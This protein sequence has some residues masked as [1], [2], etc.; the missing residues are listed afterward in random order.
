MPP[1]RRAK[2]PPKKSLKKTAIRKKRAHHRKIDGDFD[3]IIN[4]PTRLGN[5]ATHQAMIDELKALLAA[6]RRDQKRKNH[7]FV[8]MA[9]MLAETK[10]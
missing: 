1:S 8:R 9:Q 6:L 4:G 10:V 2:K 3:I 5:L 7:A